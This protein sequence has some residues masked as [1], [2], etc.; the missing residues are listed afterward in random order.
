MHML[1]ENSSQ[2]HNADRRAGVASPE[3]TCLAIKKTAMSSLENFTKRN[4]KVHKKITPPELQK[5]R[6][7]AIQLV[8]MVKCDWSKWGVH[9]IKSGR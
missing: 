1:N 9:V 4:R 8:Q 3:G 2:Y 7:W 6:K 5:D